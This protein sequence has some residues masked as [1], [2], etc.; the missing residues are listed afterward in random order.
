MHGFDPLESA[1]ALRDKI[2]HTHA[3]DCRR[4]SASRAAQEV[5]L[6]AG[7]I[8]WLSYLETL[9]EIGYQGW[10]V[11]ERESGDKRIEDI[12]SGVSFSRRLIG[13]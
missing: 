2:V 7:D 13:S 11:I 1:R 6:G 9:E 12:E 10:L 5:P 3:R 8:D 4:A